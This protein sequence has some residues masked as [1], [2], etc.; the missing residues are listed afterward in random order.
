MVH[1]KKNRS[2]RPPSNDN[3]GP[4]FEFFHIFSI[5]FFI[6]GKQLRMGGDARYFITKKSHSVI[7]FSLVEEEIDKR[8]FKEIDKSVLFNIKI[9]S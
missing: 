7:L 5:N 3:L 9:K 2:I 8:T 4:A 6:T 1:G